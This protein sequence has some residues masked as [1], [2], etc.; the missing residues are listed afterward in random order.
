[1]TTLDSPLVSIG[2]PAY[3]RPLELRRA[4]MSVLD[5][6]VPNIEVVVGDDSGDLEPVVREIGDERVV[7]FR[8]SPRLGMAGNWNAVLDR[9]RGRYVGL[10]MDDDQLRPGFLSAVIERF[11][12]AP[13]V[14]LVCTDHVFS[15]G[16]RTW[17][18]DC[19]LPQGRYDASVYTMLHERPAAVSATV[20]RS[21]VW[22]AIRPLPD[23]LTADLVM[24]VRIA[25][26]GY[27]IFYV[28]RPLMVYAVH[29]DQQ[30]AASPRFRQDQVSAWEMFSFED[31]QAEQLR[32]RRLARARV[33]VGA[34]QLRTGHIEEARLTFREAS[35]FGLVP[36]GARGLALR[37]LAGQPELARRVLSLRRRLGRAT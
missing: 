2:I 34:A 15:D 17:P 31:P 28:D 4:I 26:A 36:V 24:H 35:E 19:R 20:I 32:R 10:L 12:A 3:A 30:S 13:D 16:E 11:A 1:M 33:S 21:E 7:Y 23:L 25:L 22:Q 27:P 5:Q 8:N 6:G 18:R 14:G 37:L 29:P 9:S